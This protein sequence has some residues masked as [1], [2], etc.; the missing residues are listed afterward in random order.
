MTLTYP[1]NLLYDIF[2]SEWEYPRPADF[3]GSLEY[4][5]H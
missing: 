2:G 5:L 1:D 4:V 3:D